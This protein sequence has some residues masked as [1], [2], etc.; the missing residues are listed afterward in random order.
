LAEVSVPIAPSCPTCWQPPPVPLLFCLCCFSCLF[1]H[2][3]SLEHCKL[4]NHSVLFYLWASII[5]MGKMILF[6]VFIRATFGLQENNSSSGNLSLK[7]VHVKPLHRQCSEQPTSLRAAM[8]LSS[9]IS[10]LHIINALWKIHFIT[11]SNDR[12]KYVYW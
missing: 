10:T 8:A 9:Q 6:P 3:F 2:A 5:N 12:V 1:F 11:I 4:F 7:S